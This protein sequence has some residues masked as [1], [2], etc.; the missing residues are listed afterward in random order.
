MLHTMDISLKLSTFR[1]QEILRSFDEPVTKSHWQTDEFA[2]SGITT[3]TL[4]EV[5]RPRFHACYLRLYINPCLI[6][7]GQLDPNALFDEADFAELIPAFNELVRES[8]DSDLPSM[9]DWTASRIDYAADAFIDSNF[10]PQQYVTLAKQGLLP[11]CTEL[12]TDHP[13][14]ISYTA[15]NGSCRVRVYHRGPAVRAKY[16]G[17]PEAVYKYADR[18]LRLEVECHEARL[19][20]IKSRKDFPNRQIQHFLTCPEIA[21]E[22]L[23]R[24]AR[25]IF[26]E[27]DFFSLNM[28]TPRI[29]SSNFQKR[30]QN[31][32]RAFLKSVQVAGGLQ[33]AQTKWNQ[34][35]AIPYRYNKQRFAGCV[36]SPAQV[37]R[38]TGQLRQLQI[39]PVPLPIG[40]KPGQFPHP[41]PALI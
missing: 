33:K 27:H 14:W 13:E 35:Q 15:E 8:I 30:T 2:G 5:D 10:I 40:W 36:F 1:Y 29:T 21:R 7:T 11:T 32:L 12:D 22:E 28:S 18:T 3:M 34:G 9:E 39:N 17:L 6:I 19:G 23:S 16:P 20:S 31:D 37:R 4:F 26:D 41:F 38:I 25:R 24:Q